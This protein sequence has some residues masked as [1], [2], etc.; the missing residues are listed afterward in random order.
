MG[1]LANGEAPAAEGIKG[2][3]GLEGGGCM[4]GIG[5]LAKGEAPGADGIMGPDGLDG[6]D[7]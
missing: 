7:G 1:M 2:P 4:G 6:C 5:M 3:V